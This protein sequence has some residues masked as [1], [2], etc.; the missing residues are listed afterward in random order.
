VILVRSG[1]VRRGQARPG[2][3]RGDQARLGKFVQS[4]VR[5][6]EVWQ[7]GDKSGEVGKVWGGW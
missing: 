4:L 7:G 3:V 1:E 6:R 5:L 2:E